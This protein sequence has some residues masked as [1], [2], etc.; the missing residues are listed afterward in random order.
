MTKPKENSPNR[1]APP[2]TA[3]AVAIA[4]KQEDG[5]SQ[6]PKVIAGGHGRIAEQI[7]EIAFSQGIRVREDADLAQML[8]VVD[9]ESEIPL[10]AFATVAEILTFVYE[11]NNAMKPD[12]NSDSGTGSDPS[13]P[14]S[15][16]EMTAIWTANEGKTDD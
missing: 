8:S 16:A 9:V 5:P 12:Q 4:L 7:L 15:A 3:E 2:P 11:A 10:E 14:L 13:T 1:S 6:I